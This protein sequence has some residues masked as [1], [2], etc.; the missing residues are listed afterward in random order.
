MNIEFQPHSRE[1]NQGI[2]ARDDDKADPSL[3]R[4]GECMGFGRLALRQPSKQTTR[5]LLVE[6]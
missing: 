6:T 5:S 3:G 2:D 4:L 1:L